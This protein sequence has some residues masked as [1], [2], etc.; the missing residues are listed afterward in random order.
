MIIITEIG[1]KMKTLQSFLLIII[2][3]FNLCLPG[4]SQENKIFLKEKNY[5]GRAGTA[6]IIMKIDQT[7]DKISGEYFYTKIGLDIKFEGQLINDILNIQS[8]E[9]GDKF[10][11]K[12]ARPGLIGELITAKGQNLKVELKEV[13]PYLESSESTNNH[14]VP[15]IY[16]IE[17]FS[18]LHL[19][20]QRTEIIDNHAIRWY[21]A[22]SKFIIFQIEDGYNSKVI[23]NINSNLVKIYIDA[24]STYKSCVDYSGGHGYSWSIKSLYLSGEYISFIEQ[25]SA[26]CRDSL[27][28]D[29]GVN[30]HTY[31]AA[32]GNEITLDNLLISGNNAI[33]DQDSDEWM[34]YRSEKFAPALVTLLQRLYPAEMK[35][36]GDECD[37]NNPNVWSFPTWYLTKRGLYIGASFAR[38]ERPCDN[39]EW[40]VVPYTELSELE[41]RIRNKSIQSDEK[42]KSNKESKNKN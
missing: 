1:A 37:Y 27:H 31:N 3:S 25:W 22:K 14:L 13:K 4:F 8:K 36:N 29:F 5:K 28:A 41:N 21:V 23:K 32:T 2:L 34:T 10:A 19:V 16:K 17:K 12:Y 7:G 20:Q 15:D 35:V 9:T 33:P 39:P 30:G 18:A 38:A 26:E 11:L 6:D 24:S 42:I 40:S